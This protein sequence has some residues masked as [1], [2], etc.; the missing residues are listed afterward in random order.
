MM[1]LFEYAATLTF[2]ASQGHVVAEAT[3]FIFK[4][5]EVQNICGMYN[6][7]KQFSN[8]SLIILSEMNKYNL[9][10]HTLIS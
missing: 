6:S 9:K 8:S 10:Q 2:F 1:L 3:L 5:I 7:Y 4:S